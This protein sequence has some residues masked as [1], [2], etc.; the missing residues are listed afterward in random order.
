M[1]QDQLLTL[2]QVAD[3]LQV[4]MSTVRRRVAAGELPVVVIGRSHRVRPEDLA[5]YI[6][7][8]VTDDPTKARASH[9]D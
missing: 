5:R 3:R 7:T 6:G 4:S 2:P 8:H 1:N 9:D